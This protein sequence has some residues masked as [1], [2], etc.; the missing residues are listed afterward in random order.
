MLIPGGGETG[1]VL[2][3]VIVAGAPAT[4]VAVNVSGDPGTFTAA[5]VSVLTP[6]VVPSTHAPTVAIP[7]ASVVAVGP[8]RDPPPVASA[9]VTVM[10][11][12]GFASASLIVTDG[13]GKT[14]VP[15]ATLWLSPALLMNVVGT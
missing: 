4:P 8:A 6:A 14:G 3:F 1:S 2:I 7:F 9:K 13:A 12:I 5:A 10:P 15:T 11:A